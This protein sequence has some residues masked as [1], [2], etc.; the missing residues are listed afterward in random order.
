MGISEAKERLSHLNEDISNLIGEFEDDTGLRV[1]EIFLVDG[2]P[3][4]TEDGVGPA[5]F[6]V[7]VMCSMEAL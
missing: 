6:S 4:I 3:E 5:T 1:I 2:E 7:S